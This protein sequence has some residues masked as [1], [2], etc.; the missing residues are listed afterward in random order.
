MFTSQKVYL[1]PP[2]VENGKIK[3]EREPTALSSSTGGL[4]EILPQ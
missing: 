1:P 4:F 3:S 2:T